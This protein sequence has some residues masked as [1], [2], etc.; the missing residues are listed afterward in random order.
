MAVFRGFVTMRYT[1]GSWDLN[2]GA[3]TGG[4][5]RTSRNCAG[6]HQVCQGCM[7]VGGG[8]EEESP[9]YA[10][11]IQTSKSPV[12]ESTS[13]GGIGA[14]CPFFTEESLR[15]VHQAQRVRYYTFLGEHFCCFLGGCTTIAARHFCIFSSRACQCLHVFWCQLKGPGLSYFP[16]QGRTQIYQKSM[17]ATPPENLPG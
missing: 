4:S 7:L 9:K 16:W 13:I 14:A 12:V 17:G 5:G 2:T 1:V 10:P 8:F 11:G 15:R 6:A 3:G